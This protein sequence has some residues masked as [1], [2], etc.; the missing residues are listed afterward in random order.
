VNGQ[1]DVREAFIEAR[2]PIA[3]HQPFFYELSLGAGYRYSHYQVGASPGD[4]DGNSFNTDTYKFEG[5]W[6]PIRDIRFRASYNRAVRAPNVTDL[7]LG[8]SVALDGATDPCSG[9]AAGGLVQGNTAAQCARTGVTAAQ[10]GNIVANPAS[11]YN[12]QYSGNPLL[13]PEVATTITAGVVVQ[14]SMIPGLALTLDWFDIKV[15][16]A[17]GRYGADPILASCL[18][19][20][21]FCNL[22]HRDAQ[23]SLW[24]TPN[25][26]VIDG[27]VNSGGISTR[28]VDFGLS[29]SHGLGNI[30]SLNF[31]TVGTWLDQLNADPFGAASYDCVGFEGATCGTPSP[32]WRFK[33]RL[34]LTTPDGIGVSLQWRYMSAVLRDTMS[35]DTDLH[36]A[37]TPPGDQRM[38]AQNYFDLTMTARIGDHYNFRAG[39]NNVFDHEP[40]IATHLPGTV[41]SGNTYPQVY[42]SMGRY[43]FAGVT[44]DF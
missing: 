42:D 35:D 14:P 10:F 25:G 36:T 18:G 44:L 9:P 43:I 1:F 33:T 15:D 34:T 8:Q 31:N 22:I 11:Q 12:G 4:P 40:P 39:V 21:E 23:G 41:G 28:G 32:E 20:N 3:S 37:T 16:N 29:Y 13:I 30:G 38:P 27:N 17:I 5:A 24:R 6:A 26:Y 19:Q 7:F 2:L